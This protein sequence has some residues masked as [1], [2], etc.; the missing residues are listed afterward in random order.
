MII[1][2]AIWCDILSIPISP[3]NIDNSLT[4]I[5]RFLVLKIISLFKVIDNRSSINIYLSTSANK[6]I[7]LCVCVYTHKKPRHLKHYITHHHQSSITIIQFSNFPHYIPSVCTFYLY[8]I[9][10]HTYSHR[11]ISI[12]KANWHAVYVCVLFY[13]IPL[14]CHI[15][16]VLV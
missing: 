4:F 10:I 1:N 13:V 8:I 5:H 3:A 15:I 2:V 14:R 7:D 6:S 11:S 16:S 12:Y 9:N